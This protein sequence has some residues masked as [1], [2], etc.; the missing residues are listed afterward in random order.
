MRLSRGCGNC[1][2]D[3]SGPCSRGIRGTR[4][5]GQVVQESIRT[6]N[7]TSP[8]P[9]PQVHPQSYPQGPA[10]S[11]ARSV[12]LMTRSARNPQRDSRWSRARARSLRRRPS[13]VA[14]LN[15]LAGASDVNVDHPSLAVDPYAG[16]A[17]SQCV[18]AA[19]QSC[20]EVGGFSG[21]V[22]ASDRTADLPIA[23][24]ATDARDHN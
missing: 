11:R 22:T 7:K 14:P 5:W 3:A 20:W 23:D 2:Q 16:C 21:L 6:V 24:R 9:K 12:R 13:R 10:R 19:E 18:R 17:S 8:V 4:P 15:R 1:V